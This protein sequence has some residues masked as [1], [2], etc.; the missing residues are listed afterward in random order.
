MKKTALALLLVVLI[1]TLTGC[2]CKHEWQ[3]ATCTAPRICVKCGEAEG[4]P[5]GHKW[6]GATCEEPKCCTVCGEIQG[7]PLGHTWEDATCQS[8]KHCLVCGK[9]EGEPFD[10]IWED[11]TCTT[12]KTCKLCGLTNGEALGHDWLE[13]TVE[14]P[15][16]CQRCGQTVGEPLQPSNATTVQV[17][18][19]YDR[20]IELALTEPGADY[21]YAYNWV[22]GLAESLCKA[23]DGNDQNEVDKPLVN[24]YG[25]DCTYSNAEAKRV[26]QKLYDY[27]LP[28]DADYLSALMRKF[29]TIPAVQGT[30]EETSV[31]IY[32][33]DM[34]A[35]VS[36]FPVRPWAL[37]MILSVLECYNASWM[38]AGGR[39]PIVVFSD[40][41]FSFQWTSV[42]GYYKLNLK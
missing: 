18:K 23:V 11:A 21:D 20:G 26:T 7:K 6:Q 39:T 29:K 22:R 4:E 27:V 41:G 36:E 9:T 35:F 32:V 16:T 19:G 14:A 8:P 28:R 12:A 13:A 5:L 3:D 40:N 1:A 25:W 37:G 2:K 17:K 42:G 38:S 31:D 10:H 30:I 24:L 33:D 15:K 34:D